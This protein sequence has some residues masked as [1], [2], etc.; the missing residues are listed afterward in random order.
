MKAGEDRRA[1]R[2]PGRRHRQGD[3]RPEET[4]LADNTFVFFT[5]DNGGQLNVGASNGSLRGTKG[6]MYEG[7]IREPAAGTWPGHIAPGF[8]TD[9]LAIHMDLMPT[10]C[11]LAG[12]TPPGTGSM[13]SACCR[14][15]KGRQPMRPTYANSIGSVARAAHGGADE[16]RHASGRLETD[17]Q[18]AISCRSSYTT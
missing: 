9:R 12:I 7:G 5:S 18:R 15:L 16:P 1:D 3:V 4:G 10:V 13:A 6:D 17:S 8:R 2:A 14:S 11:A